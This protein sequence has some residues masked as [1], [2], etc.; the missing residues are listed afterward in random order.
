MRRGLLG[1]AVVAALVVAGAGQPAQA[2][3][4][5]A[6][7]TL[8]G[9]SEGGVVVSR[10]GQVFT[11]AE[12]AALV[13][14]PELE[15]SL[16]DDQAPTVLGVA[17][18][19][20]AWY[21]NGLFGSTDIVHR[22][23]V[24][25]GADVVDGTMTTPLAF[26][27]TAWYSD[28]LTE[29]D[30]VPPPPITLRQYPVQ[31]DPS[32]PFTT[33]AAMPGGTAT[34]F[35]ADRD[36]AVRAWYEQNAD[37][38]RTYRVALIDLSTGLITSLAEGTPDAITRV[39]IGSGAVAWTTEGVDGLQIH[40]RTLADAPVTTF[41]ET[42]TLVA[43]AELVLSQGRIG[44]LVSSPQGAQLRLVTGSTSRTVALPTGSA[45]LA[46]DGPNFV[47]AAGAWV[48]AVPAVGV[49]QIR[50]VARIP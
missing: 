39:A 40:R 42:G 26:T 38:S 46:S 7:V 16:L 11:G 2:A 20:V 18:N 4:A 43:G 12:G 25:T 49:A 17:G 24:R 3:P 14:R 23:D 37:G 32:L 15:S 8:L 10:A 1:A 31:A 41:V 6:Q 21:E 13:R 48:Y 35:A 28:I 19:S 50:R 9:A 44:Y 22:M 47:T 36:T 5:A 33:V 45:G 30:A 34:A 27:G 29:V